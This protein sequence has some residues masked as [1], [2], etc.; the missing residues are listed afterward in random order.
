MLLPFGALSLQ[1][2]LLRS[3]EQQTC[4]V[5]P[6]PKQQQDY[7]QPRPRIMYIEADFIQ[8]VT[9]TSKTVN[10]TGK[11]SPKMTPKMTK[12]FA[13][14]YDEQS[15]QVHFGDLWRLGRCTLWI[16]LCRACSS[17][18]CEASE[19]APVARSPR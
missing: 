19:M 10:M 18:L 2:G 5:P 15:N 16:A 8:K 9:L 17:C 13:F 3:Q 4:R 1:D 6:P 12:Y 14:C 11:D 7:S